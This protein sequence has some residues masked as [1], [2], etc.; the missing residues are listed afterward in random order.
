MSSITAPRRSARSLFGWAVVVVVLVVAVTF[1]VTVLLTDGSPAG[2]D[3]A[4]VTSVAAQPDLVEGWAESRRT[5]LEACRRGEISELRGQ[6]CPT[7]TAPGFRPGRQGGRP[8]NA[9]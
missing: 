5:L 2:S 1:A 6:Q 7:P 9:N 8:R 3:R 4:P